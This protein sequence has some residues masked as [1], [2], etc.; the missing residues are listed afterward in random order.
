MLDEI[1]KARKDKADAI[2]ETEGDPYPASVKRTISVEEAIS[3]F[4]GLSKGAKKVWICGRVTSLRDQGKLIFATVDDGTGRIQAFI[5]KKTLKDFDAFKSSVDMGD[6]VELSGPLMKTRNGEKSIDARSARVITKSLRPMPNDFYGIADAETRFRKRYLELMTEP[7]VRDLFR[8]KSVFWSTFRSELQNAGFLEVDTPVLEAT[9]GGAEAEPFT[10]HYNALDTDFFLRIS[11]E[12]SLKKLLVG[13]FPKVFEIG[14]IFRNEGID[15]EHLQDYT[16]LEFY[17]AYAD[18]EDL[19]KFVEKTYKK[20]IKATCG[21]LVTEYKGKK[22]DWSGKW[23]KV[24]YYDIFKKKTGLDLNTATVKDLYEKAKEAGLKVD[25]SLGKGRLI[26]LLF[27]KFARATMIQPCFL[28]NPPIEI[29]P[30]AK[31]LSDKPQKVARFQVVACGSELGKG[32]SEANDP[33]DER[34]RF[35]DQMKLREKG[36]AEAQMLDE[37]FLEALEYG[38]PP[39]AGFG[40]SERLFALLMDKPVR[41]TVFFPAMKRASDSSPENSGAMKRMNGSISEGGIISSADDKGNGS[42][43]NNQPN[44]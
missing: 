23:P 41:E 10:T 26:D 15:A 8:R 1:M 28:V 31:R 5:S 13:G 18:Y 21:S 22:I 34:E 16:Q 35:E 27:K 33:I 17:W 7:S 38:M 37:D 3:A 6:F 9:P 40:I 20:V 29:E 44:K 30:L 24:E 11:L 14:R 42:E 25:M 36:D 39:A 4:S 19:M 2:R 32:F 43:E 12:I